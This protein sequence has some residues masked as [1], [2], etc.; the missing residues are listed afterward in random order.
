LTISGVLTA[1]ENKLRIHSK[2]AG[3]DGCIAHASGMGLWLPREPSGRLAL[4]TR[5]PLNQVPAE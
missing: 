1:V 5:A 2:E 4:G 3:I